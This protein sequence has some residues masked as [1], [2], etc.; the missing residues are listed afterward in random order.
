[1]LAYLCGPIEF[2]EENGR[3]WRRKLG[4]FLREILGHRIY[5]PAEDEQKNLTPEEVS[6][7]RGGRRPIWSAS[8]AWSAKLSPSI[9]S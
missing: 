7:F 2:A 5:D 6:H 3:L 4:P 1:M 9:W 8:G